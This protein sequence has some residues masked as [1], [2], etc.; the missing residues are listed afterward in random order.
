MHWGASMLI[1]EVTIVL[2]FVTDLVILVLAV[3]RP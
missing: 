3:K 1:L 2:L